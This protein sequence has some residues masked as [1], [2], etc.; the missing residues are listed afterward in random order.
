[1]SNFFS[2]ESEIRNWKKQGH[3][4]YL[5]RVF[6][7]SW[8]TPMNSTIKPSVINLVL[9]LGTTGVGK[10]L[11]LNKSS[12]FVNCAEASELA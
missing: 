11:F 5:T 9:S 6:A 4:I 8:P 1:M 12:R 7:S 3:G 2:L 10:K